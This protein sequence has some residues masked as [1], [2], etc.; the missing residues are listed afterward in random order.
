LPLHVLSSMVT[1]LRCDS[2]ASDDGDLSDS[3]D[4]SSPYTPP[5][6]LPSSSG[7]SA[8]S[9]PKSSRSH[10]ILL[11]TPPSQASASP[12]VRILQIETRN[13]HFHDTSKGADHITAMQ[14]GGL[15]TI[16]HSRLAPQKL[17]DELREYFKENLAGIKGVAEDGTP[18]A[19]RC[20]PAMQSM[21][22]EVFRTEVKAHNETLKI[23]GDCL[24]TSL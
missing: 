13:P 10:S 7:P 4:S 11:P 6:S 2:E 17:K 20:Y 24:G 23:V 18:E 1:S 3:C 12:S 8:T 15:S 19:P 22:F 9:T 5:S 14:A 16:Y 21:D